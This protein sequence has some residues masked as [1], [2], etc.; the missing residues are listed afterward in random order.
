[1][2]KVPAYSTSWK[3]QI[4]NTNTYGWDNE[5][6]LREINIKEFEAST[7][8]VSNGEYLEFVEDGGYVKKEYWT[9]EGLK[10]LEDVKSTKPVFWR[11][12]G[13]GYKLKTINQEI[14]LPLD[15]PV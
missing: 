11:I 2:K 9:E 12:S 1:M 14:D 15:W 6:G 8:L 3:R 10:W 13:D 7:M 5:F 4:D